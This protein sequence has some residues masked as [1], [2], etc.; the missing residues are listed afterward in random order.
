MSAAVTA[1][2]GVSPVARVLYHAGQYVE[3]RIAWT[4]NGG[5]VEERVERHSRASR[6]ALLLFFWCLVCCFLSSKGASTGVKRYLVKHE[7]DPVEPCTVARTDD[8]RG[9]RPGRYVDIG[10]APIGPYGWS[11]QQ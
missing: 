9:T 2:A 6:H 11:P 7:R 5:A 10:W 4:D 3:T 8:V 1:K